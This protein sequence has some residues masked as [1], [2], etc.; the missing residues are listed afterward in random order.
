MAFNSFSNTQL[1][2]FLF[3][4]CPPKKSSFLKSK[5]IE[6]KQAIG[7]I[8]TLGIIKVSIHSSLIVPPCS[9]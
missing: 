3:V 9:F 1:F 5:I 2:D 6:A 4:M 7:F 8:C